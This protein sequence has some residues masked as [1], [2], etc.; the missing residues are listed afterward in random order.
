M[1]DS[2]KWTLNYE[3]KKVKEW[4]GQVEDVDDMA[5]FLQQ[6]ALGND[7]STLEKDRPT[8]YFYSEG[9]KHPSTSITELTSLDEVRGETENVLW[10][11]EFYSHKCPLCN[12]LGQYVGKAAKILD[13]HEGDRVRKTT[14]CTVE[15]RFVHCVRILSSNLDSL[16]SDLL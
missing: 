15:Y 8:S 5:W 10:I 4:D 7:P 12:A 6:Y 1:A 11:V 13:N 9:G 14:F 2:D 16:V 3:G